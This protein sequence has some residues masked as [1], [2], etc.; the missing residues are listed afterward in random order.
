MKNFLFAFLTAVL[1]YSCSEFIE[2]SVTN[3]RIELLAPAADTESGVY[4]QHFWWQRVDHALS[5][6]IQIVTPGFDRISRM[7]VDTLV[8]S[9]KFTYVLDPGLYQWRVRAENGSSHS[10]YTTRTFTIYQSSIKDQE[11]TVTSPAN[12]TVTNT[13]E[14]TLQWTPIF[15]ATRYRV[16][17]DTNNFE[18]E[19]LLPVNSL[20]PNKESP[21][22][23]IGERTYRWRVRAENET[24]QSKWSVIS[25]ISYDK[26]PPDTAALLLPKKAASVSSPVILSWSAA[27][28][29]SRYEL[30]ILKS[31]GAT[32]YSV[33]FPLLLSTTSYSFTEGTTGERILWKVRAIDETGNKSPFG[34][35]RS[36]TLQ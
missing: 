18:N 7:I 28:G 29:A 25:R 31:D 26:T 15:G 35:T 30:S 5:Y 24:E 9:D 20:T 22:L 8:K 34:E 14:T 27:K 2:Q 19:A 10:S 1:L 4:T 11:V 16:Q 12:G 6:R 21:F 23:M 33:R 17:V 13:A 36:F 3:E 32:S